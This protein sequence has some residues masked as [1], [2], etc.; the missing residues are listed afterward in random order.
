MADL[1]NHVGKAFGAK[2]LAA[3]ERAEL[4]QEQLGDLSTV[5]AAQ[6]SQLERGNYTPRLDTIL[7]LAGGLNIEPCELL[8]NLRFKPPAIGP[9]KGGWVEI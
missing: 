1:S 2:L 9:K 3:R 4:T 7:K 8:G 6:I 5:N